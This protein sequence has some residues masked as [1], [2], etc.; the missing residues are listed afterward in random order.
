MAAG[1]SSSR[2]TRTQ[3]SFTTACEQA[4]GQELQHNQVAV[5]VGDEA[6]QLVGLAEAQAAGVVGVVEQRLA[7]G[8]GRAQARREQLEP[9]GFVEGFARDEAQRDLRRRAVERGAQKQS[10]LVGH[11]QSAG[12]LLRLAIG[13]VTPATSD[14]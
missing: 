8:D 6:G 13:S 3:A 14:A 7:A 4:F 5:L 9:C 11:R 1:V 12:V 2:R 10:A